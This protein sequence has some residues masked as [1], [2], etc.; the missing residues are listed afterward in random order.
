VDALLKDLKHTV[1]MLVRTPSLTI[2]IIAA[3]ALGIAVNTA[4]FSVIN[5]VL[6]SPLP[7][8][9]PE[10]IV[11]FQNTFPQ[12]LRTGSAAPAEFNWWRRQTAAFENIS[13]YAFTVANLTGEPVPEQIATLRVSADFFRLCG[14][15]ALFGRT[16]T[17]ADDLPGAS[18]SVVLTQSFWQ[19]R[20]G[21][22]TA[23][24]GR[25]M[26]LNGED[27]E[28][29]GV[30]HPDLEDG[31]ISE[32]GLLS[33]IEI[34]APPEV[35]IPFQ[36]DPN[37]AER[38]RY[39]NV[40]GR[41]KPEITLE[42]ANAR[43]QATYP[44]YARTWPDPTPGAGFGVQ[45]LHD[46]IVG[47]VQNSLLVLF[48]AVG[49][50]LLIACANVANL[51][52]ARATAR[53]REIAVRTAV[54]AGRG[55]IV[56]QLLTESVVLS[57]V[58]GAL[59]LA[60]GHAGI[61]AVLS[62]D[63]GIPRIGAGGSRVEIDARVLG[64]TLALSILTSVLFGLFPALQSSRPDVSTALKERGNRGGA[65]VR[66]NRMREV[67]VIAE[68]ALAVVLMIGAALLIRTFVAI[69]QVDPGFDA[70][71]VLTMRMLP[72]GSRFEG[73]GAG[74]RVIND[75]I[76]RIRALP[77]VEVA[78]VTC[79]L[80]L[81]DRFYLTLQVAGTPP[82][83][84]VAGF[85]QISPGYFET[86]KI[87]VVRGREFTEQDENGPPVAIV[88]QT[89]AKQFWPDGHPLNGQIIL[90]NETRSIVGV[91]GDVRDSALNRNPRPIVYLPLAHSSGSIAAAPWA[92]VIRTRDAST[93][94]SSAIEK[95]LREASG[96][97]PVA[98]AR[99][100]EE[101]LSR[102]TAAGDFYALVLTL[103]GCSAL[104][105]AAIGIYG[106]MAYSVTE[107]TQELGIRMAL[108]AE[109][110]EIRNMVVGHGLRLALAGASCGLAMALGLTRLLS[111]F[112]YGVQPWDPDVFLVVP[113][114]LAGV[115]LI[116]AWWPAMGA[117]R[118]NPM[119]ALRCE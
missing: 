13:A 81:E 38:G 74:A 116:A 86:F 12:G 87:P 89:L 10:R 73:A 91:V 82:S 93:S 67:L 63:P 62:L 75:G 94:L 2:A 103:F 44:D 20:F 110:R 115:A 57:L 102:S 47:G 69:R 37:S 26:R 71:N 117:A 66:H 90:G 50:V 27:H 106:L 15:S 18:K 14:A 39:F 34:N 45:R 114:I 28:I 88:N 8:H 31:Q 68:M 49:F 41:L 46:A 48:G 85:S 72:T 5:A 35:Y 1:R 64:F 29:I 23:V 118:L 42:A 4:M 107:R 55:R 25:R 21:G 104:L 52:L 96:G 98:R 83:E 3:L 9:E 105:L 84:G 33:G 109:S 22:D 24:I 11:M 65:S 101:V 108:G 30:L 6:L 56:R 119:D 99:T 61:L 95:E 19:R 32:Q 53:K 59:G 92:W 113:V 76:R 40:A 17:A 77:G 43:L 16:F 70:R 78:A 100:M 36:L 79:C 51:L 7:Y 111:G 58:G 60:I 112:L 54:G 80:P 97:L